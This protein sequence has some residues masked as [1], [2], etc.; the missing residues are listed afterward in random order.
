LQ[1]ALLLTI[2]KYLFVALV[3][4]FALM[5][6]R[7]MMRELARTGQS[8]QRQPVRPA[9]AAARPQPAPPPTQA[10][11]SAPAPPTQ[12][13]L[14]VIKA[15]EGNEGLGPEIAL[16]AAV[17]FGRSADNSV[18]LED[19]YV[20]GEHAQVYLREGRRFLLDRGSTNGT[21]LNG[22]PVEGEVELGDRD[23][24]SIGQTVFEYRA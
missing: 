5:V 22:R 6:F 17:T 7:G 14:L 15:A 12:S 19:R 8:P 16:S 4:L 18:T 3:Y 24:I 20:S 13:R 9:R 23:Q 2:G 11:Q 1:A 10:P 21:L